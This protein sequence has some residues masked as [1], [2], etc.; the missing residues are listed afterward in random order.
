MQDTTM[1]RGCSH[2]CTL[3][4]PSFRSCLSAAGIRAF[5]ALAIFAFITTYIF[6]TMTLPRFLLSPLRFLPLEPAQL[7][8]AAVLKCGQTF[9]W[10]RLR[11]R[12]TLP[13]DGDGKG[14]H[15]EG[16]HEWAYG[17]VDRTIVLRQDGQS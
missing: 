6:D 15:T 16:L 3:I 13:E 8:L 14:M 11:A 7:S 2:P 10:K 9:L 12:A 4:D 17:H 5:Y 1:L